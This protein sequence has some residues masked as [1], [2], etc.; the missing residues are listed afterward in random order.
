MEIKNSISIITGGVSGLGE[1]TARALVNSGGKVALLDLNLEKGQKLAEELG[2]AAI[3]L[4][5]D[6]SLEKEVDE[7][8][9]KIKDSL[10]IPGI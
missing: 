1:A 10:F 7:V 4:P 9:G 5:V 2:T 3:F 6:I 8:V